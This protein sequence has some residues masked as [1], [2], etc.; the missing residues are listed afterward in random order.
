M[1]CRVTRQTE[2][3]GTLAFGIAGMAVEQG[4]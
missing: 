2:L 4:N 3:Q 1:Y